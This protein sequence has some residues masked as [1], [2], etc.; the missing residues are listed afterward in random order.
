MIKSTD[1]LIWRFIDLT[2]EADISVMKNSLLSRQHFYN[3]YL[4]HT[5]AFL[6]NFLVDLRKKNREQTPVHNFFHFPYSCVQNIRLH[7]FPQT[8]ITLKSSRS[9]SESKFPGEWVLCSEQLW[10]LSL[11]TWTLSIIYQ[12]IPP[13]FP[14]PHMKH[15]ITWWKGGRKSLFKKQV[16]KNETENSREMDP[17]YMSL[18]HHRSFLLHYLL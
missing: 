15:G 12:H 2:L 14:P 17:G 1:Y 10:L 13:P 9:S 3:N 18:L 16:K 7:F 4:T 8:S 5:L 6:Q 11:L